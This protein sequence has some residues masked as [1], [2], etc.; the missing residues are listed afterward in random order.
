MGLRIT[1]IDW[2]TIRTT[3]SRRLIWPPRAASAMSG[4]PFCLC[5]RITDSSL[6]TG[7]EIAECATVLATPML[8]DRRDVTQ[9][10]RSFHH[11]L[12]RI[13]LGWTVVLG[14]NGVVVS[15]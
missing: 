11:V 6:A 5:T 8:Q 15:I 14:E 9:F 12:G 7:A 2:A 10:T 3:R 13:A 1:C 4:T